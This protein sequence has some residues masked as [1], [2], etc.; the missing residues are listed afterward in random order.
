MPRPITGSTYQ[1]KTEGVGIRWPEDGRE[2]RRTGF[3]NKT[4]AR[5][6]FNETVASRL[7]RG[8]PSAQITFDAFC[9]Q[10]LDQWGVDVAPRTKETVQEW[11]TPA[12]ARFGD[13]T[14]QQLEGAAEDIAR[15]R[16]RIPSDNRRHK[17]IRALRQVL[18]AAVRWHYIATN[19]A[20]DAGPN[21]EPRAEEI[22]P[23]T[24]DEL[25]R[26]VEELADSPRDAGIVIFAAQT[27]LR[28]SEWPALERRDIDWRNPAV[29]VQRRYVNRTLTPYPKT[30]ASRRRVPLTPA[31]MDALGP[32]RIDTPIL[33]P[34]RHGGRLDYDYWRDRI[35]TPALQAAGV[36]QRGPYH[37]RHTFA[38]EAL[39]AGVSIFQL[40][41]LMGAS[42]RTIDRHYAHLAHDSETALR[43]LLSDRSRVVAG[44]TQEEG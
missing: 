44:A 13:W 15:W 3:R 4:E 6:W 39:A 7:R 18:A 40:S 32:R 36:E 24:R 14:L 11:L 16:A 38:T 9:E 43:D 41:R 12:R 27:G 17:N 1:T 21:R 19:P 5:D 10:Y 2:Q 26:I 34:T 31:A 29:A 35:W 23:F 30:E 37:L 8:G 20:V 25:D 28:T 42:V 22:R 33:F